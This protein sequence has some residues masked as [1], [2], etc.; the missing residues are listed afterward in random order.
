MRE[1]SLKPQIQEL[2]FP[3]SQSSSLKGS[4]LLGIHPFGFS[5]TILPALAAPAHIK[6]GCSGVQGGGELN[7]F[8][9]SFLPSLKQSTGL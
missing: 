9:Y 6:P 5:S 3:S 2:D 4:A 1:S 8:A 7:T